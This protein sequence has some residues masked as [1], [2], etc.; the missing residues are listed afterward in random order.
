MKFNIIFFY[1]ISTLSIVSLFYLLLTKT[2][3]DAFMVVSIVY[4]V[5][6]ISAFIISKLSLDPLKKYTNNLK[7]I[8]T[9][10]LHELNLP[11]AT[12]QTNL[13]MIA[14]ELDDEKSKKRLKRIYTALD[15]LKQRYNEL[16]YIIKTQTKQV[17]KEQFEVSDIIKER[18]DFF[19]NIFPNVSFSLKLEKCQIYSDKT[20]FGKTIDN[21][22]QNSIKYSKN[23]VIDIILENCVL[24]I[25]DNGVGID[26]V[27]LV[28]IFDRYYQEDSRSDGFGVGLSL[29]KE[30]CDENGIKLTINSKKDYGTVIKLELTQKKYKL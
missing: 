7:N 10:T 21:I 25:K 17:Q 6:I 26:E 14:K 20:G 19:K 12:I 24:E 30:F 1:I 8:S 5:I 13:S 29:V 28:K 3:L 9:Q 18:V 15:M 11:I 16:D 27:E 2:L 22:L 23:P 4:I